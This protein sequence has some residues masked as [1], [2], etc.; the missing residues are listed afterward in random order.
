MMNKRV[1]EEVVK[2][3]LLE[4]STVTKSYDC[5]ARDLADLL[6]NTEETADKMFKVEQKI[7]DE[8]SQHAK[9]MEVFNMQ[10][11]D[12]QDQCSHS[13]FSLFEDSSDDGEYRRCCICSR[14]FGERK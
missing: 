2:N 5:V 4:P 3:Y 12:I 14:R 1:I 8:K 6:H 7:R 13:S 9:A 11:R 10:M